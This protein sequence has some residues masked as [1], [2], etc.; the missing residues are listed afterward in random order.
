M[1]TS[2][3]PLTNVSHLGEE[4]QSLLRLKAELH[5]KLIGSLNLS[6]VRTVDPDRLREELRRGAEEL[7]SLHGGLL[8]QSDREHM[9]EELVDETIGLGPLEPLMADPTV[10][11]ILINGPY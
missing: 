7:C 10:S 8:S 5:E 2:L 4:E 3:S 9:V 11:D 1:N 6:I